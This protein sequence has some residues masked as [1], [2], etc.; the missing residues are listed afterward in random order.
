[1]CSRVNL[2]FTVANSGY[3]T[4]CSP[5]AELSGTL[6]APQC[7]LQTI[8]SRSPVKHPGANVSRLLIFALLLEPAA[9]IML[10][11]L[12][13]MLLRGGTQQACLTGSRITAASRA[14]FRQLAS[15]AVAAIDIHPRAA[16][17]DAAAQDTVIQ[18]NSEL[19]DSADAQ[20][21]QDRPRLPEPLDMFRQSN[22]SMP[23]I[24]GQVRHHHCL[25]TAC[26]FDN[27]RSLR[28]NVRK[29]DIE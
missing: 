6:G 26:A 15:D 17:S 7:R 8:A 24:E 14:C 10:S 18:H 20:Q 19:S 16:N 9:S 29:I 5:Y 4:V 25:R 27:Q 21:Q 28:R 3:T 13:G 22:A 23:R 11:Q 12:Q 2:R 1:M